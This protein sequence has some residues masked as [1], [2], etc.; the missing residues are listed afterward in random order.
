M[1]HSIWRVREA[2]TG[3]GHLDERV[4]KIRSTDTAIRAHG[5]RLLWKIGK[6][7]RKIVRLKPHHRTPGRVE[8]RGDGVRHAL[9]DSAFRRRAHFLSGRHGLDPADVGT[10]GLQSSRLFGE[11]GDGIV[12]VIA[13]AERRARRLVQS[14]PRRQ[15][16]GG[17]SA[18]AR[19]SSAPALLISKTRS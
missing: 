16:G 15:R 18:T 19:A 4:E 3:L 11:R 10:A 17:A 14:S 5:E 8:A 2:R 12:L 6:D 13:R 9:G 1:P 7:R